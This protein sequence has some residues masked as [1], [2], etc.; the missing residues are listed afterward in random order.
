MEKQSLSISLL[1]S[2]PA[3]SVVHQPQSTTKPSTTALTTAS[4]PHEVKLPKTLGDG[5]SDEVRVV[6]PAEY[7]SAAATLAAAFASDA[8]ARYFTH[9]PDTAAWSESRKWDLHVH[10]LEYIVYAHLL[11]GLVVSAGAN[12]G[13]VAL[14]MPPGANMDDFWTELRSGMWRL[15]FEL[16][17]LGRRRFFDEFLPLLHKTKEEVLGH[18]DAEAWYLVYV[19]TRPE[20]RGRG[21]ARKCVG[22]VTERADRE[23]R[24]CYLESSNV[25][26]LKLYRSLGFEVAG[27]IRLEGGQGHELDVMVREPMVV[28]R[29]DSGMEEAQKPEA[30]VALKF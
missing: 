2:K 27:K 23:G 30:E 3:V 28:S 22:W 6:T 4:V 11:K 21:L 26:N 29:R 8:V 16:S 5:D 15:R 25:G 9:T 13:C 12:H 20:A 1:N 10:I 24:A 7:K 14:W 18:R 17:P 19:G